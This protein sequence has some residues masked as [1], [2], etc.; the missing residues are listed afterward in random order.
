MKMYRTYNLI[1]AD[2][3]LGLSVA[4]A[5]T[6]KTSFINHNLPSIVR[7][8]VEIEDIWFFFFGER[9]KFISSS[10]HHR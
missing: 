6:E 1:T 5:C 9:S 3:N 4:K 7:N 10:G 2:K 8:T